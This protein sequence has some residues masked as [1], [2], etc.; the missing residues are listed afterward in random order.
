ME[1]EVP[2]TLEYR[3]GQLNDAPILEVE[4]FTNWKN[5]FMCQIIGIEPQFENI[6]KN[7]PYIPMTTGQRKPE[8][9]WTPDERKAANLD[10]RLKSLILS[11]DDEDDTKSSQEYLNDL[12]EEYQARALLAKSKRFFK[13][14]TQRFSS[15][16]AT[17]QTECHKCDKKGYFARDYWSKTLVS[18]YQSPFESKPLSPSQHK[19]E[20]R[21]TKD[22]E[23]KYNKFKAKLA[24]LS[25]SAS[26][27]KAA[28]VKNKGLIAEAYEWDEEEVSSND[29]EMV[30]VKVFMALAEDNDDVSKEGARNGEWVKISMRKVHT[31]LEM[32][33]NDDRKTYLDYLCID[34]NYVEEQRINL[35]T[36]HRNLVQ[37]L[38]TCKEQLLWEGLVLEAVLGS[39]GVGMLGGGEDN[40][41]WW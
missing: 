40:W 32:E 23:A 29:N 21:P 41:W 19:P 15:A 16:K 8:V 1:T 3:V 34:L 13:K 7:D 26:S 10:Q 11:S 31:L 33:D 12:E 5:R 28:T 30:K 4:N 25:S 35:L 2:Q 39:D 36:K 9:K 37:E 20:L 24:H 22:F 14:G 17:N 6:I 18:S 38:N 27:S